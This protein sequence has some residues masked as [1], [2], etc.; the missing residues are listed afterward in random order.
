MVGLLVVLAL[1]VLIFGG[2][3]GYAGYRY[4]W[5]GPSLISLLVGLVILVVVLRLL[6]VV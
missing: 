1:V 2:G 6:G 4:G 3:Y 5:G